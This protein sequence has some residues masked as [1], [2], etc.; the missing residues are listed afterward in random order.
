M[1]FNI[2]IIDDEKNIR[3]G[4]GAALEMDGYTVFLAADGKQGLEILERGDIDLVITDLK[5]PEVSGEEILAKV[6]GETP[7]IPVIVLTGHG[8]ID[9]AVD[10]MRKG[11]YD[12][13]TKPVNLDRLSLLVKRALER[14]E[15]SLQNSVY[16]KEIEGKTTFENMI[17]KSHEIQ[18]VFD[19]VKKV[20][21]SKASVLITGESG[22]GKEMIANALHNLSPRKDKPF[23]KVHCA[24]LSDSLLESELFGHEKGAFTGAI[25]MK[26]GRFELAHEGTIFL[27]EI[28]EISQNVQVKLLRVIQERKFERVGGEETLDVDVRIIAATNRNLEEEIKKGNF[29]EDLYYRLNVVNI[30]VPPLRERKDDIPIMVNNFI[31]K[32]SKENNKNITTVDTKA[33]N[34]LYSY[35]WPGNIRELRNCIEGAVVIA[36]G[37]TLRL[38]DL[39]PAVRKSQENSSISIPAGTDMD[40]A[41]KI[42]IRE[43]LLFCHGNKSKTAQVLG[44]GRKTLHRK[45]MEMNLV[46]GDPEEEEEEEEEG[47][48]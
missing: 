25:A 29:R 44:I 28:G 10:A 8:T 1:K 5:M 9:S 22:V 19:L 48:N 31:R 40:T 12:F 14:R 3:E 2:L 20:A 7:G 34:A 30:N 6:T 32:F 26:R 15:I 11:A 42:I 23:I 16:R 39:P 35:D 24:A 17:G 46:S 38:E 21:P 27:D 13:L 43:T 47:E 33:K 4:L 45:L 37:S 41:E 36:E 18:K